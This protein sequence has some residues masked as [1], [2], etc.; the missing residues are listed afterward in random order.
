[1]TT[2][3]QEKQLFELLWDWIQKEGIPLEVQTPTSG[4]IR[5]GEKVVRS[6]DILVTSTE[7]GKTLGIEVKSGSPEVPIG[8]YPELKEMQQQFRENNGDFVVVSTVPLSGVLSSN[9]ADAGIPM[10]EIQNPAQAIEVL[11][12]RL[13]ALTKS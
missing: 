7:T 5:I 11:T 6:P 9:V 1:M 8:V 12:P 2:L 13:R 4:T 3:D 10:I